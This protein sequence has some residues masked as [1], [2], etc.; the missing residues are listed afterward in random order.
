M[1]WFLCMRRD[2]AP[3]EEWTVD[4]DTHL[5]WMRRMH[6]TGRVVMSGPAAGGGLAIY[7]IRAADMAAARDVAQADPFV[8]AGHCSFDLYEWKVHQIMGVGA[9]GE[10]ALG[11][12]L[13]SKRPG[14]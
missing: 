14:G 12:T 7:L 3:R 1:N 13:V 8:A 5:A 9:F 6:E 2:A 11:Q 4:R 10:A